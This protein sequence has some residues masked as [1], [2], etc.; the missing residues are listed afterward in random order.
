MTVPNEIL[1]WLEKIKTYIEEQKEI[2]TRMMQKHEAATLE[3]ED[4]IKA[5]Q[6][7]LPKP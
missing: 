2:K 7:L 3:Y 5:L 1:E 6:E 4:K